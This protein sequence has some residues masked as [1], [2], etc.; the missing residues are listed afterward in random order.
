M[1]YSLVRLLVRMRIGWEHHLWARLEKKSIDIT[2]HFPDLG[3]SPAILIIPSGAYLI[4]HKADL[5]YIGMLTENS[6]MRVALQDAWTCLVEDG[7]QD[8]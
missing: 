1:F 5:I 3:G 8:S 6:S 2:C 7:V 4:D